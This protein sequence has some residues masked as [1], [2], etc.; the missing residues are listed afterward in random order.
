M[1]FEG[2]APKISWKSTQIYYCFVKCVQKT[3]LYHEPSVFC[4]NLLFEL[5]P[6]H[7]L[8]EFWKRE[9]KKEKHNPDVL[10]LSDR[11]IY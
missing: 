5:N 6:Y 2:A 1:F 3:L 8:S 4:S 7:T 10:Q 11:H 9:E